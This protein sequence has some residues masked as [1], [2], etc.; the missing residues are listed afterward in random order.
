MERLAICTQ[1]GMQDHAEAGTIELYWHPEPGILQYCHRRGVLSTILV[2]IGFWNLPTFL[3]Q[4]PH[5]HLRV[6]I[7]AYIRLFCLQQ[8]FNTSIDGA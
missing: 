8:L 3:L 1:H 2:E 5:A 6:V 7:A 4:G